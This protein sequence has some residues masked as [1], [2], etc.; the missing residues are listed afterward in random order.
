MQKAIIGILTVVMALSSGAAAVV[1]AEKEITP[2][3][4]DVDQNGVCDNFENGCGYIDEDSDGVCDYYD[5]HHQGWP[6]QNQGGRGH[7]RNCEDG[8]GHRGRCNRS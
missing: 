6:G 4:V 8:H 3:F 5:G 7:G 2:S 1:P